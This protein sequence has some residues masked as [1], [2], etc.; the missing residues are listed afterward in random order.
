MIALPDKRGLY[1]LIIPPLIPPPA[2]AKKVPEE[3][4]H[5][6]DCDVLPLIVLNKMCSKKGLVKIVKKM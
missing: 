1:K 2:P 4:D 5:T 3:I 6:R